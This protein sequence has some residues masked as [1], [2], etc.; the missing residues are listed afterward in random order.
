ME[1]FHRVPCGLDR[2]MAFHTVRCCLMSSL[3]SS[4]MVPCAT[5]L[6]RSMM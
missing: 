4:E 2:G 1:G 6:P 5:M 3:L